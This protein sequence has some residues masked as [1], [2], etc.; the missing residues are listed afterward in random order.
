MVKKIRALIFDICG[1]LYLAK[2][3]SR[4]KNLL[5][6]FREAC[7][8]LNKFGLDAPNS[9]DSLLHTYL[10]SSIGQISKKETLKEM[11]RELSI[12]PEKTEQLFKKIY[13]ENTKE[14]K[15]L[16]SF[17]LNLK[18]RGYLLGILSTLFHLSK[19]VFAPQKYFDD[20]DAL[21]ISCDDQLRKPD[22]KSFGLILSRLN[23]KAEESVFIDDQEKNVAAAKKLGMNGVLFKDNK[24]LFLEFKKL[25]I[26]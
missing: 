5:N 21:E 15:E 16:Y 23:V 8:L 12:S 9:V 26:Q 2:D 11:S 4:E 17:I 22:P 6:S 18:K 24:S 10:K 13:K 19:P 3:N 1:V 14:N 25:G 20:F 7:F